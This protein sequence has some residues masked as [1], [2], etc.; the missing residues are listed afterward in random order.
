MH[1]PA[2]ARNREPILEVLR[3]HLPERGLV[4]EIASGSGEHAV[5]FA[6]ALPALT[7]Q[8]TD[9]DEAALA[10]IAA[11]RADAKLENLNA[12]LRLDVTEAVWPVAGADAILAINMIHISPWAATEGLM[13]GAGRT[14]RR[15]GV[16]YTYGPY[17]HEGEHTAPS[18]AAFDERLRA[19][20]PAFGIR[21]WADVAAVASAHGLERVERIAMPANNQSLVFRRR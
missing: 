16:L 14:L 13:R 2:T 21:D 3:A 11:H 20:N 12:P 5:H 4:L 18:N 15:G 9:P 8:P 10:S 19:M 1:A 7:F 6:A 17:R